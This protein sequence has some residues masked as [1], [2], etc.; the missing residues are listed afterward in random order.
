MQS[1]TPADVSSGAAPPAPFHR[2]RYDLTGIVQGVGF[3]PALYRLARRAG[4]GG[5][6]RNRSGSVRLELE[7]PP[8]TIRAFVRSLP[9]AL[10]PNARLDGCALLDDRPLADGAEMRPFSIEDSAAEGSVE[11][12]IPAD[13][14][15]CPACLREVFDPLNRRHGYAFTTCTR[16]GPRYTVLNGMPYDRARTTMS[17]FPPCP[18]CRR[19]Y[20]DPADR[21]FHAESIACPQCGP[22]LTIEDAAGRAPEGDPLRLARAALAEGA[23]LAVRGMGGFLLAADARNP[24]TLRRLRDRKN[25]PHKPFAV[26]ARN[27]DVARAAGLDVPAAADALLRSAEAPIVILDAARADLPVDL[28]A[29]DTRTLGV[30]L[31]TTPLH[32]LLAAPLRGDPVPPF[33]WL[34]MTSGNRGGEPICISNAEA[35]ERL[36]GM[37]DYLLLHDREINLRCDD[38]LCAMQGGRPRVWRRA[39]GFAPNPVR[40]AHPLKCC[41]LAMGAELKNAIAVAH[42]DRVVLSPHV[43][44]LET[45][46][47]VDGLRQA[48]EALPRFINRTPE[49]VAVD[50]HPDMHC[51]RIGREIAGRLGAR[52][53]AVQ[54]HHAHAAAALAEHGRR[55]GLALVFDGAGLGTDGHI[56]GAEL[57]HIAPDGFRRLASFEGAPLPGGDA[58][59]RRPARQLA[60]RAFAAGIELPPG[61]RA[62]AGI[63]ADEARAWARQC[64][65]GLN[66]PVTHAAGRLFDSFCAALGLAAPVATYEGQT[67]IRLEAAARRH[68]E[69][70]RAPALPWRAEER[71]GTLWI[72]WRET[73]AMLFDRAARI[74]DEAEAWAWAAHAAIA[75]AAAGMAAYGVERTGLKE[76]A[77]SGG[78]FMN[79]ILTDLLSARLEK[80]G[81]TALLHRDVPPNDGGIALGQAVVAGS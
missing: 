77:L 57:L 28:I 29:P 62:R 12:L 31:P 25:R 8:E 41:V 44:D 20:D 11:V 34:I 46:E 14:A 33:D 19:E 54:H 58:A 80:T 78:V 79:R 4:L 43:G 30:M 13:L 48:A 9:G 70:A 24:A 6:V 32:A 68:R 3:R 64:A 45:P 16:C 61:L 5:C 51:T 67:A 21:R 66:A 63:G 53:A 7:G 27:P 52:V 2:A 55:T 73:F 72:D 49:V 69:G 10:P 75:D 17:A 56:W 39:R 37:A 26:M 36:R 71:E 1:P 65:T 35:R 42:G 40:T 81:L 47:A 50:L 22:R 59:V 60:G 74:A 15:A 18:A 76:V 23:V 38:S